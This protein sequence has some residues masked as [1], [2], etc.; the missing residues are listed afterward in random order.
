M[1]VH[2]F[3]VL[4]LGMTL[5]RSLIDGDRRSR[6]R[7]GWKGPDLERPGQDR[8]GRAVTRAIGGPSVLIA[9]PVAWVVNGL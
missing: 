9:Q 4:A 2:G 5:L 8:E 1:A 7:T 6:H 3:M